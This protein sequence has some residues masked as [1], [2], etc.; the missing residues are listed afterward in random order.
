MIG[1]L[2]AHL[3]GR[4]KV[5]LLNLGEGLGSIMMWSTCATK[6]KSSDRNN[7]SAAFERTGFL[8]I[9]KPP[10]RWRLEINQNFSINLRRTVWKKLSPVS[11]PQ[12][13]TSSLW[14][15]L[16]RLIFWQIEKWRKGRIRNF[17]TL[18]YLEYL[19]FL[20]SPVGFVKV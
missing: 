11:Y 13:V 1:R 14:D 15:F 6:S 18:D 2:P 4:F 5:S 3:S 20:N 12:N 17:V 8:K 19:R 16:E 7:S 9:E 10:K